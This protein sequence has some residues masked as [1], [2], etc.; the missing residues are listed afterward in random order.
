MTK[1]KVPI[2]AAWAR[3]GKFISPQDTKLRMRRSQ[4]VAFFF[5]NV[6]QGRA[7]TS[8]G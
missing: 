6:I 3:A 4:G 1:I 2:K 7:V 8:L 5:K